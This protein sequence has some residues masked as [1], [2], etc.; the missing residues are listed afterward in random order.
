M[1]G[2]SIGLCS[3]SI[4]YYSIGSSSKLVV[5]Q[6]ETSTINIII[7]FLYYASVAASLA[8]F[9]TSRVG[10][11]NILRNQSTRP[12]VPQ[13]GRTEFYEGGAPYRRATIR[14]RRGNA[15]VC[16]ILP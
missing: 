6:L 11:K 15:P 16:P 3:E 14:S 1:D 8:A 9:A 4:Y 12:I 5:L 13:R 2:R 10:T 7:S